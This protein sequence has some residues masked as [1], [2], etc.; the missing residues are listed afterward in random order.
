MLINSNSK[1]VEY[2]GIQVGEAASCEK[3]GIERER[4]ITLELCQIYEK[5]SKSINGERPGTQLARSE[6]G[7]V[8]PPHMR[9]GAK[10]K[11]M[12]LVRSLPESR[13]YFSH[14]SK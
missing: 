5:E 12:D 8:K 6:S 1:T 14:W 4:G 11:P 13:V 9:Q 3:K 10:H 7:T 2:D